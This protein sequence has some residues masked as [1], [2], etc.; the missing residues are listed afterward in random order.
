MKTSSYRTKT[1]FIA[2]DNLSDPNTWLV[3]IDIGYSAVKFFSPNQYGRFP[4]YAKRITTELQFA[5][6]VPDNLIMYRDDNSGDIWLVGAVPQ[7]MLEDNDTSD[8]ESMLYGRDRYSSPLFKAISLTGIGIALRSNEYRIYK[9]EEIII[10]SGLPQKYSRDEN[11]LK[12]ALAGKHNFSIKVGSNSWQSF[13]IDIGK[14]NI[15]IMSQPRG[16][17]FSACIRSDGTWHKDAPLYLKKSTLIFD[18]GF[19]TLDVFPIYD[20][21]VGQGETFPD[22][23]MKRILEE[24]TK[25]IYDRFG[26]DISI[27][28]MQKHLETGKVSSFNRKTFKG[29]EH[30]IENSLIMAT[31]KVFE[32]AIQRLAESVRLDKFNYMIITGGVGEAWGNKLREKLGGIPNLTLVYGNQNDNLSFVYANVRGYYYYRMM[33]LTGK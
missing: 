26:I 1:E 2:R 11:E 13:N 30:S 10:Q 15:D 25:D 5:G 27:A 14:E 33:K 17:L 19:G 6:G 22:L 16:S 24:T 12:E 20:G 21:V 7:N 3:G 4:S 29:E 23:G 31:Q 8:S 18:P 32:E 9:G 28:A